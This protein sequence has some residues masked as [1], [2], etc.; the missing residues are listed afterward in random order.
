VLDGIG[1][2]LT[3]QAAHTLPLILLA[4]SPLLPSIDEISLLLYFTTRNIPL[5]DRHVAEGLGDRFFAKH[6]HT[7]FAESDAPERIRMA[8]LS[9]FARI[10]SNVYPCDEIAA[11]RCGEKR[12]A[13]HRV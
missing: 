9:H 8:L 3:K 5:G 13:P 6:N 7:I 4:V 12:D 2:H 1:Q 10:S 11:W